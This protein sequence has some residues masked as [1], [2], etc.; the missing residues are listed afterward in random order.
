MS[1][2]QTLQGKRILLGVSGGIA[3]Y[4]AV[5]VVRELTRLGAEV[6]VAMTKAAQQFVG[7]LTFEALS[8]HK[9]LTDVLELDQHGQIVH[10][11]LGRA[12]G[13][14]AVAPATCDMIARLAHGLADDPITVTVLASPAPLLLAPAMDH[15]MWL[16][17]ATQENLA[18]LRRRGARILE[19]VEGALASGA[20]GF[21]RMQEPEA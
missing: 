6:H 19:P 10:V 7:A 5:H 17:A 21:G 4:K 1:A 3:C 20:T 15:H 13:L 12:V 18:I 2:I 16:N 11:E 9:V 14:I 8:H